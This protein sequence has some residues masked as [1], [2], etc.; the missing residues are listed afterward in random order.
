MDLYLHTPMCLHGVQLL[1]CSTSRTEK[2]TTHVLV[3]KL[4]AA[5]CASVVRWHCLITIWNLMSYS[6]TRQASFRRYL[7]VCLDGLTNGMGNLN[8]GPILQPKNT[9]LFLNKN[10]KFYNF[11]HLN[12]W[13]QIKV[14]S[15]R[16]CVIINDPFL[17]NVLKYMVAAF[18][19]GCVT[20]NFIVRK[21]EIN[22]GNRNNVI[23]WCNNLK[24]D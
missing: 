10:Q 19:I 2:C 1:P 9:G 12:R 8:W 16:D 11:I 13:E 4:V 15:L 24:L 18:N 6:N 7:D 14:I 17:C 5:G 22:C 20:V 23:T 3:R 21:S